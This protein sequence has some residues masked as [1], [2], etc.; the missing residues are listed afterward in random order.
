MGLG[1]SADHRC[2]PHG[3]MAVE[4]RGLIPNAL[5][6]FSFYSNKIGSDETLRL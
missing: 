1:V 5:T 4:V 3:V 6:D 2:V